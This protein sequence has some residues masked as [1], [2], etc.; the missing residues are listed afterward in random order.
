MKL[1]ITD[2]K[3]GGNLVLI[4]EETD[5]GR[6]FFTRDRE[7]KNFTIAWNRGETQT[8]NIDN[9]EHKFIAGTLLPL[10]F[11]QSFTF[12]RPEE[13]VA[14]QFNREFY[15]IVDNDAEVSCAGFLF[16]MG[17][18]LFIDLDDT[19]SARL[20]LLMEIFILELKTNDHIQND[21]VIMLL[22][23]LI[24]FVTRLA[25]LKYIP[26]EKSQDNRLD[27]F[28]K[29]NLLVEGNFREEHSVAY[30]AGL[31]NKSPKTLSNI[32]ALY[33]DKTPQQIIQLRIILEAK[34]L[35][36]YTTKSVKQITYELGFEDPAY[37]CNF[38][39]RH[40]QLSPV[41]FRTDKQLIELSQS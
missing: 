29:F 1:A 13:I 34:R 12:E 38:F 35:L 2:I 31:L 22:K 16:G 5:F 28:R 37:F 10:M 21:M 18:I 11:N 33:N 24:I 4:T 15:C 19:T 26:N 41:E 30:Y 23:R 25:R 40:T 3:T 6:M 17:E 36:Y 39:K 27:I 32:F 20:K 14:W 9:T 7:K 8:V